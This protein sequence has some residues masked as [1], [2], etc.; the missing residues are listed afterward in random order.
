MVNFIVISLI[1]VLLSLVAC[2]SPSPSLS[3]K[4]PAVVTS[5]E[6]PVSQG[7]S[8]Q[9]E[10]AKLTD[11]AKKEKKVVMYSTSASL[12]RQPLSEAFQARY[13]ISVEMIF[14]KGAEVSEKL[15]SE[16]RAGLFIA[17][18]YNGGSGTPVRQ[19]KPAGIL[20]PLE[21]TLIHPE[22]KEAKYWFGGLRWVDPPQNTILSFL[23]YPNHNTALNTQFVK[24]EE[25]KSYRDL[26]NPRFK[27]KIVMNDPT[28]S[29]TGN[30][31]F[32]ILAWHLVDLDF[33]RELAKLEP[34]IV[35]DQR[36]QIEWLALNKY[37]IAFAPKP[38]IMKDFADAG[39]PLAYATP[40]EGTYLSAGSGNVALINRA[41]H[42]NAA[43]LLINWLLSREGGEIFSKSYGAQSARLDVDTKGLIPESIRKPGEKYW[44]G[45][46]TEEFQLLEPEQTKVAIQIFGPLMAR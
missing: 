9:A 28:L 1:T 20:D 7:E 12:L 35:R 42:P 34:A 32:R 27:G 43:R 22:V 26:I 4:S 3:S 25:I 31:T 21:P 8:W 36:L 14:G 16:R 29:G 45:G 2:S 11:G 13:G 37:A 6:S 18:V 39:A 19:L 33:F 30:K 46:D 40:V 5:I 17:D 10:W 41:P 38:E 44:M 24:P 23:A 15:I